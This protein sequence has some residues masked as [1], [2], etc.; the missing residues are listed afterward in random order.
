MVCLRS[1]C[2]HVTVVGGALGFVR[3]ALKVVTQNNEH[4]V[5]V[6]LVWK[7]VSLKHYSYLLSDF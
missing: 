4:I 7:L 5:A 6:T 3:L 2:S 1:C